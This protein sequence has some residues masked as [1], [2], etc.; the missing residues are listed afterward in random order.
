MLETAALNTLRDFELERRSRQ[1]DFGPPAEGL[2]CARPLDILVS[3]F[4]KRAGTRAE[5]LADLERQKFELL[6]QLSF[7]E[8]TPLIHDGRDFRLAIVA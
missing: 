5:V 2:K 8:L 6:E 1:A 3:R 4:R 7:T